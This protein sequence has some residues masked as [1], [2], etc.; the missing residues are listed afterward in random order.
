MALLGK[1]AVSLDDTSLYHCVSRY[2]HR[3]FIRDVDAYSG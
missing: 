2:V 1:S 3:A